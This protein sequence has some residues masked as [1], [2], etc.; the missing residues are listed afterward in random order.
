[1]RSRTQRAP[2]AAVSGMPRQGRLC[3]TAKMGSDF[4]LRPPAWARREGVG[5]RRRGA[6]VGVRWGGPADDYVA[7]RDA[8]VGEVLELTWA[9]VRFR[10]RVTLE[11][12]EHSDEDRAAFVD[13]PTYTYDW[14]GSTVTAVEPDGEWLPLYGGRA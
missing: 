13:G 14:P 8:Q 11:Y 7:F 3:V 12:M 9:L 6:P 4:W 1:M 2:A 10:Q 5:A